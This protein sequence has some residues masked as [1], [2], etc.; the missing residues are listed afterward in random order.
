MDKKTEELCK[1]GAGAIVD[2]VESILEDSG[3][4]IEK[5]NQKNKP[6]GKHKLYYCPPSWLQ[7]KQR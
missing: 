4:P 7:N 5:E 3:V 2:I 1:Q 6:L